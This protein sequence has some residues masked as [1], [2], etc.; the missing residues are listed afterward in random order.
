MS[1]GDHIVFFDGVCNLCNQTIDFIIKKDKKEIFGFSSL[2]SETG[3]KL[4]SDYN[5]SEKTDSVILLKKHE[6]FIESEAVLEIVNLLPIPWKWLIVFKI[7]PK[8]IRDSI[9]RFVA[10]KRYHWFG[11]KKSCRVPTDAE[12][13]RFY[14]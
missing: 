7:I 5:I 3:K 12:K 8:K 14:E 6:V 11:K 9:Y 13:T 4:L 10:R 2:Q 1:R